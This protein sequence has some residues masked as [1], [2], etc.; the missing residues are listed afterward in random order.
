MKPARLLQAMSNPYFMMTPVGIAVTHFHA[1]PGTAAMFGL[2]IGWII[3]DLHR[4]AKE[5]R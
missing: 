4:W 3:N 1:F 5:H 2:F